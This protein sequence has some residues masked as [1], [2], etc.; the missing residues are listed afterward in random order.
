MQAVLAVQ[1]PAQPDLYPVP[2]LP[3][4]YAQGRPKRD[5]AAGDGVDQL[6][7]QGG[8]PHLNSFNI[9]TFLLLNRPFHGQ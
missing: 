2:H 8:L 3:A 9:C 1:R 7:I 6:K 5:K 4:Q